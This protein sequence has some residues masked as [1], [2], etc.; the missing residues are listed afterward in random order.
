VKIIFVSYGFDPIYPRYIEYLKS[1]K[2][3]GDE[4]IEDYRERQKIQ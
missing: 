2:D 1:A 4:C 3:Y